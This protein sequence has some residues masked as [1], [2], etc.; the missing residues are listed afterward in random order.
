MVNRL[1]LC[2]AWRPC[3]RRCEAR[4]RKLRR[5]GGNLLN[6]ALTLGGFLANTSRM[7][8]SIV[9]IVVGRRMGRMV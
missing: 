6:D 9:L 4:A 2:V 7:K 3:G 1:K 8:N 5:R